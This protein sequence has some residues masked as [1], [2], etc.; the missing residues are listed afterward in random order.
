M[1]AFLQLTLVIATFKVGICIETLAGQLNSRAAC[2]WSGCQPS[3]W[4]QRGCFPRQVKG[5]E[6]CPGGDKFYCCPSDGGTVNSPTGAQISFDEFSKAVTNNGYPQPSQQQYNDFMKRLP[7]GSIST[8][9]EA[10][11]ALAQFIHESAGLTEKREKDCLSDGCP[12]RYDKPGCDAPGRFYF[13]RGYIQLTGCLNYRAASQALKGNDDLVF[14]PD[15]VASDEN[16]AWDTAFWFWKVQMFTEM[17]RNN[18]EMMFLN[19]KGKCPFA[20][21]RG[22]WSLWSNNKGN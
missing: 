6:P 18:L 3:T 17:A 12:G 10:A 20:T 8:K 19:F 1:K 21:W 15:S 14:N 13:G 5:K 16:L 9:V 2:W 7:D 22:G 4:F 11:M